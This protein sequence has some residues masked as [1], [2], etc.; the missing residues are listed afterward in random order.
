M[1]SIL[2]CLPGKLSLKLIR[3][4]VIQKTIQLIK[5]LPRSDVG[6][7][8][9][10]TSFCGWHTY[11]NLNGAIYKFGWI[12]VPKPGCPCYPPSNELKSPNGNP[13]LDA[14]ISVIAHEL[15]EAATDPTGDGWCYRGTSPSCFASGTVENADQSAWYFPGETTF[16]GYS[17]NL[18]IGTAKY[19]VQANWNLNTQT[20][21]MA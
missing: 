12:G 14:A 11:V 4:A 20:C 7:A 17:Y 9:F 3:S 5:I 21:A 15:A 8:D 6:Q 13:A 2:C 16:N 1:V 18:V 10:C 19:L